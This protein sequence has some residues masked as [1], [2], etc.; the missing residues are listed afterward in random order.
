[1]TQRPVARFEK[2][3]FGEEIE[4]VLRRLDHLTQDEARTTAAEIFKVVYSLFQNMNAV[5]DSKNSRSTSPTIS[6]T[7]ISVD[8]DDNEPP[9]GS[10]QEALGAFCYRQR[11]RFVSEC[12]LEILHKMAT[13]KDKSKR[14]LLASFH[15]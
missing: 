9:A 10:V 8:N 5:I 3:R 12:M 7:S 6:R 15:F 1:M 13:D 4:G 2:K 11:A 14:E